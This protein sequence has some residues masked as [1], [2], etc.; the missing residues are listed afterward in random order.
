MWVSNISPSCGTSL[1]FSTVLQ[2]YSRT[3]GTHSKL[4]INGHVKPAERLRFM[5]KYLVSGGK[6]GLAKVWAL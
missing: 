3:A 2:I 5:D 4:T 6:D 1:I